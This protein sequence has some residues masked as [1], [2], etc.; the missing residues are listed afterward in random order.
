MQNLLT[1]LMET[2]RCISEV[3]A[4]HYDCLEQDGD[5]DLMLRVKEQKLS[6]VRLIPISKVCIDAIRCQ[7]NLID[8]NGC[9]KYLFPSNRNH[10]KSPTVVAPHINRALNRLAAD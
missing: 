8:E 5:G 4:L 9:S 10:S 2:G 6:R 7:Q 3:C 1:I